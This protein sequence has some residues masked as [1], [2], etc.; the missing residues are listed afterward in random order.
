MTNNLDLNT[1]NIHTPETLEPFRI[2]LGGAEV[3]TPD[4]K[5]GV[6]RLF[7]K[8]GVVMADKPVSERQLVKIINGHP[9]SHGKKLLLNILTVSFNDEELPASP[10]DA[11]ETAPEPVPAANPTPHAEDSPPIIVTDTA[12]P[13]KVPYRR[14]GQVS[15]YEGQVAAAISKGGSYRAISIMLLK[16]G[17]KISHTSISRRIKERQDASKPRN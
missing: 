6:L 2:S 14:A 17:L 10:Q 12:H 3:I 1:F 16:K 13:V 11:L 4:L 5:N 9:D 7:A 15:I 8:L